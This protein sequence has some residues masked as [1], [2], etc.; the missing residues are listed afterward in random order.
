MHYDSK[1]I[2]IGELIGLHV[3]VADALDKKQVG[4]SGIVV[5]ETTHTIRIRRSSGYVTI[6]KHNASFNFSDGKSN[7]FV[8]GAEIDFA[9]EDRLEKSLRYYS[10][11]RASANRKL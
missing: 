9:P 10:R 3:E 4:I 5:D 7:F 1:N 8:E 2:V 6:I 11:R